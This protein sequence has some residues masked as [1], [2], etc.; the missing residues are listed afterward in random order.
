LGQYLEIPIV[1]GVEWNRFV[2]EK[3]K[4]GDD[5][6]EAT[7]QWTMVVQLLLRNGY[8]RFFPVNIKY[9]LS[10]IIVCEPVAPRSS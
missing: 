2:A 4:H 10:H 7:G 1:V 3:Q 6:W 5:C 8:Q 9:Y